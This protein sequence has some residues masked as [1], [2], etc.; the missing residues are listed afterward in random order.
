MDTVG[1]AK[2]LAVMFFE[3]IN[4]PYSIPAPQKISKVTGKPA[5]DYHIDNLEDWIGKACYLIFKHR[6]YEGKTY[7]EVDRQWDIKNDGVKPWL[8]AP[9]IDVSRFREDYQSDVPF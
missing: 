4:M 8:D 3:A 9:Q 1:K 5:K 2:K 7:L 6:E